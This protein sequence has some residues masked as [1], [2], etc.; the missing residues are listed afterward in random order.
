MSEPKV[1][2][3][4]IKQASAGMLQWDMF[5]VTT[6]P[7]NGLGPVMQNLKEHLEHQVRI[8]KDGIMLAAGPLWDDDEETWH[9]EGVFV[10][11]ANSLAHAREIADSDPMHKSGAR[12]YTV[13]PWMINEGNLTMKVTFSD[14]KSTLA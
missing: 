4:D 5:L 9:G 1:T 14:Q 10:I 12:T 2:K 7:S 3:T 6:S 13:R 8:E 11:R